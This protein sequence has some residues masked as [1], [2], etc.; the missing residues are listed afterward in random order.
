MTIKK[1]RSHV[2][3]KRHKTMNPAIA[4]SIAAIGIFCLTL[5]LS[6]PL[7]S[8]IL[9]AMGI[10]TGLIGLNAAM[11]PLGIILASPFMPSLTRRCG[12]WA[13]CV[14]SLIS[15][16]VLLVLIAVFRDV[17]VWFLLRF[18]LGIVNTAI[19]VTS[20]TWINQAAPKR[21]RGRIIGLYTT[22]AAAGFALGPLSI[23]FTGSQGWIPFAI[24]VAGILTALPLVFFARTHLPDF[25]G[26]ETAPVFPLF[27]AAPL[28]LLAVAFAALFDQVTISLLPLYGLRHGLPESTASLMLTVLIAGNV[29]LQIPI[30]WM[31]DRLPRR[32]LICFLSLATVAGSLLLVWLI[33]GTLLIWPLLFIWGA[34]AFG[35]YTVAM[36]EL[37]DRFSGTLLLAGNSAFGMMWGI[38]GIIG[39]SMAGGAMDLIG[40]EGLPL[41]LGVLFGLLGI[42]S[43]RMP[44]HR[45]KPNPPVR[46]ATF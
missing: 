6:Y 3:K 8:L 46:Q 21:I 37:G 9:D 33:H 19:F 11:T 42:A 24:G 38:G 28:L 43:V 7:L 36:V 39:P 27:F 40:P 22:V 30:G 25:N 20:E 13:L 10:S 45:E 17:T 15:A 12:A 35:T 2:H 44:S 5:G 31:A 18:L 34:A 32:N 29:L 26:P 23:A 41:T 16:A 1:A 14:G 4:V